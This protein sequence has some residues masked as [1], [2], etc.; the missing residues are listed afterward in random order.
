MTKLDRISTIFCIIIAV[1]ICIESARIG[2]GSLSNP[3]PGL[4]P[5]GCG[6]VLGI[7]ASIVLALTFKK[8]GEEG[9]VFWKSGTRW[10]KLVS[11]V[12]SIVGYAFSIG[13]LG[14]RLVTFLWMGYVCWTV[15]EMGWKKAFLIAVITTFSSYLLFEHYLD[16]H[17]PKGVLGF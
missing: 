12:L 4:V 7:F 11:I 5:L 9:E 3:G 14:F 10:R 2:P 8:N 16:I 6:L 1:A 15:G 17:F 13:F